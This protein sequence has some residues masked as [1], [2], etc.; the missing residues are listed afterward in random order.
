M[1]MAKMAAA[2]RLNGSAVA[3]AASVSIARRVGWIAVERAWEWERR[4]ESQ[5]R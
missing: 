4:P 5:H 3:R 2:R 1:A